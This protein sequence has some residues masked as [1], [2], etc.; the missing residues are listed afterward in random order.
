MQARR[1]LDASHTWHGVK[2]GI[3][4]ARRRGTIGGSRR[5]SFRAVAR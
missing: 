5:I 2:P 4:L 3:S 1:G